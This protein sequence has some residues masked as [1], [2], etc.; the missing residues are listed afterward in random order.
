MVRLKIT[1]ESDPS[2]QQEYSFEK[3]TIRIGR[4][5]ANELQLGGAQSGVSRLHTIILQQDA[6]YKVVDNNSLNFTFLNKEKLKAEVEYDLNHGDEI[7][8]CDFI[9]RFLIEEPVQEELG[10]TVISKDFANPFTE[11]VRAFA[12]AVDALCTRYEEEGYGRK[13][14]ALLDALQK[15][16]GDQKSEEAKDI[17]ARILSTKAPTAE[18]PSEISVP[19]K[20]I[21]LR[22]DQMQA[23]METLL[24]LLVKLIHARREF[25]LEFMGETMIKLKKT[26]S[27]Y[28]CTL[29]ELKK[30]LLSPNLSAEETQE[31]INRVKAITDE[32][33][34]HQLSMLEGYKSS[35]E[36]GT[37]KMLDTISPDHLNEQLGSK[38][39]KLGKLGTLYKF[40][41]ILGPFKLYQLFSDAH[42]ELAQE[43]KS[44][45][46][47]KYFRPG[48]IRSYN[49]RMELSR[50]KR[51]ES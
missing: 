44:I 35:V 22:F 33:L 51:G 17:I 49:K 48:Y 15:E 37:Q 6:V 29:E 16:F 1:K 19:E 31:R 5:P 3:G 2:W 21:Q 43:D 9:I 13:Q 14:E 45:I 34:I 36:E 4:D 27:I 8:I 50:K 42:R 30:Y 23:L 46:E 38:K 10:A 7:K 25:R 40:L 32:I 47:K 24:E 18:L 26:F 28:D 12:K 20:Q 11:D 39:D 41:P